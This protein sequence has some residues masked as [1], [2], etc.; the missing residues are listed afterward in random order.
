MRVWSRFRTGQN[1][2]SSDQRHPASISWETGRPGSVPPGLVGGA[3]GWPHPAHAACTPNRLNEYAAS[4]T[5]CFLCPVLM[6]HSKATSTAHGCDSSWLLGAVR[7]DAPPVA[8]HYYTEL[9]SCDKEIRV[10]WPNFID[11]IIIFMILN[12]FTWIHYIKYMLTLYLFGSIVVAIFF[13]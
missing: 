7:C 4:I 12:L 9:V 6:L 13:L 3:R 5:L 1:G 2:R 10:L 8:L 11:K